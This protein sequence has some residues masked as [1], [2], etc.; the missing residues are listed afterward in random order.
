MSNNASNDHLL[1]IPLVYFV[2]T[3]GIIQGMDTKTSDELAKILWDYNKLNQKIENAD[4]I[5][6]LGSHDTRVAERGA[7]L[8]LQGYAPYILFSGGFGRLTDKDWTISEAEVFAS[9]ALKMGVPKETI[10]LENK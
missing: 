5:V 6:V 8:Y 10:L 4:V 9:I 3:I 7:E 1:A 2:R